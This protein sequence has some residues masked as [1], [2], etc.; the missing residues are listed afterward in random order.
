MKILYLNPPSDVAPSPELLVRRGYEVVPVSA[1]QD[2]LALIR[3]E[4]F[5]A[6]LIAEEIA[7]PETLE[8]TAKVQSTQPEVLVFLFNE[9]G[10][11]LLTALESLAPLQ[12][13]NERVN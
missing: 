11:E 8:F 12:N 6:V 5:D 13:A 3:R 2:A 4:H 1:R 7:E 10:F 9:C